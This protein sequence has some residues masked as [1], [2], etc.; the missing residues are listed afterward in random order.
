MPEQVAI[1]TQD[2]AHIQSLPE[3]SVQ[4]QA[5]EVV[6]ALVPVQGSIL[7]M[8]LYDVC[9]EIHLDEVRR[10]V[11]ARPVAP[12]FKS[13]A[14]AYVRFARPPV[15]ERVEPIVLAHGE[16]LEAQIK[17]YDYGV[18]SIIFELPFAGEWQ[19]LAQLASSWMWEGDFDRHASAIARQK[20][21]RARA[22]LVK[23]YPTWLSEDYFIFQARQV[24]GNPSA[25]ELLAKQGGAIAQIVRGETGAIS[26]NERNEV[27]Q[28]SISYYPNDLA[29]IGWNAAFV[30]DSAVGAETATELLEYANSQLLEFRHYDELLTRELEG[31]YRSLDRGT[32]LW[33]RWR[34][35]REATRLHTVLLDVTELSER[36]DNAIKFLSDMFSARLYRVAAAKVGVIDYKNLVNQKIRTAEDLYRFMVDQFHQAR[37]FAIEV[38]VVIILIVEF[39]ALFHRPG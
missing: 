11:G 10:I 39:I 36:A 22:A 14:P 38:L 35:A 8:I 1:P 5:Q 15:V 17:Y 24:A 30:Y 23:P 12:A 9:E 2:Q 4:S 26:D 16:R 37:A 21:E 27:L 20:L 32:G 7:V 25:S 13:A 34:L 3:P 28:S 33:R 29:V 19:T 6:P 31:V 18:V